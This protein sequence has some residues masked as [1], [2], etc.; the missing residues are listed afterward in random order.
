[1]SESDLLALTDVHVYRGDAHVL[2]GVTFSI[3]PN[4]VTALLGRNGAGKSTTLLSI[5]GQLRSTGAVTF[6]GESISGI[7]THK[8]VRRNIGYVPEDREVF[9][10]LTVAENLK[11]AMRTPESAE[12]LKR[13]FELFPDLWARRQQRA[14]SLSG[15]QQQM[16]SLARALLNPNDLLLIDEPTKGLAPSVVLDVVEAL[17]SMAMETTILLVEQNLRVATALA[18]D[19][20]V[21]DHGV[22]VEHG[23]MAELSADSDRVRLLLGAATAKG[24]A[25]K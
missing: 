16:I 11:L 25:T 4:R 8:L 13:V 2:Q 22:V 21:L 6:K 18:E 19:V 9:S 17:R 12:R 14:G 10:G 20:V 5:L 7:K 24:D 23:T 15:G 3:K 1:M